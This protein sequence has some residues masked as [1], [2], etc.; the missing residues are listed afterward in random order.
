MNMGR[1]DMHLAQ[2]HSRARILRFAH[3]HAYAMPASGARGGARLAERR[4]R[5]PRV[6]GD[7]VLADNAH[8]LGA[9]GVRAVAAARAPLKLAAREGGAAAAERP[10]APG[11]AGGGGKPRSSAEALT[12]S[13]EEEL[14]AELQ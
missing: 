5:D 6:A 10:T 8:G 13:W 3:L 12:A 2:V 4:T 9:G 14:L 11:T 1:G 7:I